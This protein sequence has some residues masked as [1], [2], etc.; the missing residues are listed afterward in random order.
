MHQLLCL[1]AGFTAYSIKR[2]YKS[3]FHLCVL[4][5]RFTWNM[6]WAAALSRQTVLLYVSKV[7]GSA[8]AQR[9]VLYCR[10]T[11]DGHHHV[12]FEDFDG[13]AG[14]EVESRK[15]VSA[16]DEG[17]SGGHMGGLEPHGEGPEA[18]LS[19]STKGLTALEEGLVEVEADVC[20]QAL[21]EAL[22]DLREERGTRLPS[23]KKRRVK[24]S[25]NALMCSEF[26]CVQSWVKSTGSPEKHGKIATCVLSFFSK[27]IC[28]VQTSCDVSLHTVSLSPSRSAALHEA[29]DRTFRGWKAAGRTQDELKTQVQYLFI[30]FT[31]N[32]NVVYTNLRGDNN[33][34]NI[35]ICYRGELKLIWQI[36]QANL[37]QVSPNNF[38]ET[39]GKWKNSNISVR[40]YSLIHLP[41]KDKDT[42]TTDKTTNDGRT[43]WTHCKGHTL[44]LKRSHHNRL[45]KARKRDSSNEKDIS[46]RS[47]DTGT[48]KEM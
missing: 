7:W 9:G 29:R 2:G 23:D 33:N 48:A 25:V 42:V 24:S 30:L 36:L 1:T 39:L 46:Y 37:T 21:W 11:Q 45:W 41:I 19:R 14:D 16:V 28:A 12:V 8:T 5:S 43:M 47:D 20:L 31:Q 4:S 22:Q 35:I 26:Q 6:F 32:H 3:L 13:A 10:P 34:K 40:T 27:P 44:S 15:H 17:V 18:A 38:R